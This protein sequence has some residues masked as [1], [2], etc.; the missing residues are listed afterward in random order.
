MT[1]TTRTFLVV[2][3][4]LGL[5][6][7]SIPS[8]LGAPRRHH[9]THRHH[10]QS[11]VV[12]NETMPDW[13]L[14]EIGFE[15][16]DQPSIVVTSNNH[17]GPAALLATRPTVRYVNKHRDDLN[18]FGIGKFAPADLLRFSDGKSPIVLEEQV[19]GRFGVA[20]R[21]LPKWS[22]DDIAKEGKFKSDFSNMWIVAYN[23]EKAYR[24]AHSN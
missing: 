5:M 7:A 11:A 9:R 19:A 21:C 2:L 15:Q 12:A 1:R 4:L 17:H 13:L 3:L 24:K 6:L 8:A 23:A 20:Y 10:R 16:S 22:S 14:A 18:E